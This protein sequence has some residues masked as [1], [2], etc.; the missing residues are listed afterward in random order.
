MGILFRKVLKAMKLTAVEL[1]RPCRT[2][3]SNT[4][5]QLNLWWGSKAPFK[6]NILYPKTHFKENLCCLR[7][8]GRYQPSGKIVLA[9]YCGLF[10]LEAVVLWSNRWYLCHPTLE[11]PT[12]PP[13]PSQKM[14]IHTKYIWKWGGPFFMSLPWM[15]STSCLQGGQDGRGRSRA[16]SHPAGNYPI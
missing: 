1:L 10:C 5:L 15:L 2:I 4:P 14:P 11:P 7:G 3:I 12:H 6:S 16:D 8:E 9:W 13:P